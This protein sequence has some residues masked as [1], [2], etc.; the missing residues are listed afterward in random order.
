[1]TQLLLDEKRVPVSDDDIS[2]D[3]LV[4]PIFALE[5]ADHKN[6]YT[7][8]LLLKRVLESSPEFADIAQAFIAYVTAVTRA[9]ERDPSIKVKSLDEVEIM[10][11]KKIDNWIAEGEARGE[12]RGEAKGKEKGKIEGKVEGR[13]EAQLAIALALLQKGLDKAVI[14]EATELSLEEIEG[15]TKN[16]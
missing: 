15:L 10:L 13:K 8:F 12:A 3:N 16:V 7:T 5:Q 4:A 6:L 14:A 9:E 1:M 2:S 11:S